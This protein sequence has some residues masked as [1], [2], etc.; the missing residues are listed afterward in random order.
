[1][2]LR[3]I[4]G[5][6]FPRITD[7]AKGGRLVFPRYGSDPGSTDDLRRRNKRLILI[8]L[9]IL[10]ILVYTVA[11]R[12][13]MKEKEDNEPFPPEEWTIVEPANGR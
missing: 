5:G 10:V 8:T 11:I 6:D 4:F 12:R 2:F 13:K 1:M 7:F 3:P 9:I